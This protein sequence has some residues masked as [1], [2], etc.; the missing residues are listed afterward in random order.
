MGSFSLCYWYYSFSTRKLRQPEGSHTPLEWGTARAG[1]Y[2]NRIPAPKQ[3]STPCPRLCTPS[4][5]CRERLSAHPHWW[6]VNPLSSWPVHAL[7]PEWNNLP[8]VPM[9]AK[10]CL[11]L[12]SQRR[13][14]VLQETFTYSLGWIAVALLCSLMGFCTE[15]HQGKIVTLYLLLCIEW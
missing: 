6:L 1:L 11:L 12:S 3:R 4:L 5:P 10:S 14:P 15:S 2:L 9:V 13:C 8:P 7:F